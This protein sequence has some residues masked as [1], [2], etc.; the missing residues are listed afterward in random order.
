MTQISPKAPFLSQKGL[1]FIAGP[2]VIESRD[3]CFAI[4]ENIAEISSQLKIDIIFKAS[5]Y[6]ANRTSA[7]GFRGPGKQEGLKI[8]E[9]IRETFKLPVL[10][11]VHE[12]VDVSEAAQAVDILQIPAFLC[13][14]T[15]LLEAAKA[16]GKW[17][18]VKKGQFMS[19]GDMKFSLEKAGKNCWLTERGTF[20][21]YNKLVVDFTSIPIMKQFGCDVVFDATHSVQNPGGGQGCSS[22]NRE[23]I[24]PLARAAIAA[25]ADA[26]FFEVHPSPDKALCDGPNS[27]RLQDFKEQVPRLLEL[28][29]LI[30]NAAN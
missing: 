10:T 17:V 3:L 25:G 12:S 16:S 1:F 29:G 24:I 13:R 26:L 20:F 9:S 15:G 11:D 19:P 28:A 30:Q 7:S 27:L 18:N 14:Q 6:K 21:G 23:M 8:L 4:A 2:C 5:Y 22:G